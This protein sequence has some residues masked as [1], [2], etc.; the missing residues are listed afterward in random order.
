MKDPA[1]LAKPSWPYV[2]DVAGGLACLGCD[3]GLPVT[4]DGSSGYEQ[5]A[6]PRWHTFSRRQR[7]CE[8]CL[9]HHR[10]YSVSSSSPSS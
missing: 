3:S 8:L 1:F 6:Q 2:V 10:D 7:N 9:P 4:G 5:Q